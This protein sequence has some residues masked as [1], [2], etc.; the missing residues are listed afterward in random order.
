LILITSSEGIEPVDFGE[1]EE[2]IGLVFK[3]CDQF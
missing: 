3:K 1:N 2:I